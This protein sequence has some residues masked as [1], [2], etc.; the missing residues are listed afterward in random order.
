MLSLVGTKAYF[1]NGFTG[2]A[3]EAVEGRALGVFWGI[4]F[5][6]DEKGALILDANGFPTAAPAESVLGDPNPDWIG[7]ITNTFSFKKL[8]VLVPV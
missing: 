1:L 4:G 6:K 2:V 3:S 8:Y 5:D 7:G